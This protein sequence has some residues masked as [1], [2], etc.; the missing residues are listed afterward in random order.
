MSKKLKLL[1]TVSF[2]ANLKCETRRP[3]SGRPYTLVY[4]NWHG[5]HPNRQ[6]GAH[7]NRRLDDDGGIEKTRRS[8][9]NGRGRQRQGEISEFDVPQSRERRGLQL[10]WW[11]E[12]RRKHEVRVWCMWSRSVTFASYLLFISPVIKKH[13]LG[14]DW[15]RSYDSQIVKQRWRMPIPR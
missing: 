2:G 14:C 11:I 5:N 15:R 3:R 7:S 9:G 12:F 4:S 13:I 6:N 1:D 8:S 10:R